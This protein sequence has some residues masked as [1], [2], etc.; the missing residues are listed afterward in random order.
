VTY[1]DPRG[2]LMAHMPRL[3]MLQQGDVPPPVN[4]EVDLSNR[5]QLGCVFCHFSHV[6]VRGPLAK[7]PRLK[8]AVPGG[9]LMDVSLALRMIDEFAEAGVDSISWTGGGEPLLHK[10]FD[11]IIAYAQAAGLAQGIYTNGVAITDERAA[12]LKR[13]MRFVYVSLDAV[14][15]ASYKAHKVVDRFD[16]VC[17]SIRRLVA[18]EGE[19]TIG[20]GFLLGEDNWWD[21]YR[22][23]SLVNELGA[24]YGQVR[25]II[26]FDIDDPGVPTG[27]R[28]WLDRAIS[29][30]REQVVVYPRIEA[31]LSRFTALRDWTGHGYPTCWWSALQ[32]VV[33]P[34]GK[35]FTC[36]NLREHPQAEIGDLSVESFGEI[37]A[38][39]QIAAVDGSCRV[40]C[41]GHVANL[42]L[43]EILAPDRLHA[44]FV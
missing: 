1:I 42:A 18:T 23:G 10:G 6:H 28:G 14:N 35:M 13:T 12:L 26:L 40:L 25:P 37:W 5:C 24:D 17:D 2:K 33:T 4:I 3:A 34:S 38:R 44:E 29:A 8:D 43:A 20:V 7:T 41:R 31:D 9:D 32:A 16:A 15:A 22:V 36:V 27:D 19:A 30:I 21:V 11:Q 39:R